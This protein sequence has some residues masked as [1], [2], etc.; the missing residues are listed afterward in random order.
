MRA[1]ALAAPAK[2][3]LFLG[4]GSLRPDGYHSV[5]TVVHALELADLVVLT[6]ADE[7]TFSCATD[8]GIPAEDNL[9][10]LAAR[11]FSEA[12]GCDVLIDI[13]LTKVIPSGAGLGGGSAD[14][15][16]VLAGLAHWANL[17]L[18]DPTLVRVAR[19]LGADCAFSLVGG[20]ALMHGRGDELA[21]VL[22]ALDVHVA[23]LK[24]PTPVSTAEA[25]RAFDA[26]PLPVGDPRAVTDAL[27]VGDAEALGAALANNMTDVSCALVPDIAD[28][29][30]WA[31]A[32]SG[33]FGVAMAGSG[34]AV[35]AICK[36]AESAETVARG[37]TARGW[38]A[39]ATKTRSTGVTVTVRDEE[40]CS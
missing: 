13:A 34:S 38:W 8:L 15:A 23:L 10:Y 9:A 40:G 1:L 36:S 2:V 24:P 5:T 16:A 22:P 21:R 18:D 3:N 35:F 14:A 29:L 12:Y 26:S 6:P 28:A 19:S 27:R 31:R 20:A 33:V 11:A 4:I 30:A 7:L 39:V 37:A 32:Q 25:Y 17:P